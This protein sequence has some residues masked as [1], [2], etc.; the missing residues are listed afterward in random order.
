MVEPK[1]KRETSEKPDQTGVTLFGTKDLLLSTILED[2]SGNHK[3]EVKEFLG[4][5]EMSRVY[6]AQK[7]GSVEMVAVKVLRIHLKADKDAYLRFQMEGEAAT[8]FSHPR[9]AK[10]FSF[11]VTPNGEAY[12]SMELLPG[13]DLEAT[14]KR[15][16]NLGIKEGLE[17]FLQLAD[18]LKYL[19]GH[20]IIHRDIKPGNVVLCKENGNKVQA[21]LVDL[22]V[23]RILDK[24]KQSI[25]DSHGV[26]SESNKIYIS[27][28]EVQGLQPDARS[29]IFS[30]GLLM[31]ETLGLN[32]KLPPILTETIRRCLFKEPGK[33]YQNM[34]EVI[35]A[36]K[37]ASDSLYNVV[38]T[39]EGEF[40]QNETWRSMADL[41]E[42]SQRKQIWTGAHT[43]TIVGAV[44]VLGLGVAIHRFNFDDSFRAR[45]LRTILPYQILFTP[46]LGS[47]KEVEFF[48]Q[49]Q[50][51][52][53]RGMP[54]SAAVSFERYTAIGGSRRF[55]APAELP[56]RLNEVASFYAKA[57]QDKEAQEYQVRANAS[58]IKSGNEGT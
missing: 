46:D 4:Q 42:P 47:Q 33:R 35:K 21:K 3:M 37:L 19:H 20:G 5:G 24:I 52:F 1:E 30:F 26:D 53:Q 50:L 9:I 57:G 43:A 54:E 12:L 45:C 51:D 29:D 25:D 32:T 8:N 39:P 44:T 6:R 58:A 31:Q 11:G 17:I 41:S 48:K 34:H 14:L 22:G 36:L 27:T 10:V 23:A 16:G 15:E 2:S 55:D 7:H 38:P 40:V 18:A 28:Q 49:G 56:R 13:E